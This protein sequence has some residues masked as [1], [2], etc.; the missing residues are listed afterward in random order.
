[1]DFL[2]D[3]QPAW[4]ELKPKII[5]SL[6]AETSSSNTVSNEIQTEV[7]TLRQ[8]Y[9]EMETLLESTKTEL[10]A[11]QS[12]FQSASQSVDLA[13]DI[14]SEFEALR[15]NNH[16]L[17]DDLQKL[18][19]QTDQL[20]QLVETYRQAALEAVAQVEEAEAKAEQ[21]SAQTSEP[22]D[23]DNETPEPSS[24]S[25]AGRDAVRKKVIT[26][27]RHRFGKAPRKVTNALKEISNNKAMDNA[28]DLALSA[29]DLDNFENTLFEA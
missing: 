3:F 11:R 16:N 24:K 7:E 20:I 4:N 22:S 5:S 26:V 6:G 19:S 27:L 29:E 28:F 25:E 8:Q 23:S 14:Q 9:Q 21:A 2:A 10:E 1:M 17:S 13:N 18:E 12:L 15:N